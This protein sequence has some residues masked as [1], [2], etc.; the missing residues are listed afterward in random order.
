MVLVISKQL[1]PLPILFIRWRSLLC[2]AGSKQLIITASKRDRADDRC[3]DFRPDPDLEGKH[4]VE[5]LSLE[6][7]QYSG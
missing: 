4:L 7:Q 1:P 3:L 5:F 2:V 6:L